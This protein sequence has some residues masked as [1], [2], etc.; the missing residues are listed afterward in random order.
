MSGAF[1]IFIFMIFS[2]S[3]YSQ[4]L[5][6]ISIGEAI[7]VPLTSSQV[8]LENSK[9]IKASAQGPNLK[10]RGIG[11]GTSQL[12][13]GLQ[14]YQFE[15]YKPET[16]KLYDKLT[17][18]QNQIVG[19]QFELKNPWI[20]IQ[21]KIH[22]WS[23]WQKISEKYIQGADLKINAQVNE[24]TKKEA[25][26]FLQKSFAK[27]RLPSQ[28]LPIGETD[29]IRLGQKNLISRYAQ[30]LNPYGFQ[31]IFDE[32]SVEVAP[33]V[34]VEITVAEVKRDFGRKIG[35]QWPESY[36]A[37][38]IQPLVFSA[39]GKLT[40]NA[41]EKN[42]VAKVL[43]NPN[44][45]CRSNKEAEFM[46]GGE[47]PIKIMNR[48]VHD[49]VWKKYGVLL[50]IKPQADLSGRISLSINTEIS[51]IDKANSI[52]DMPAMFTNSVSSHFDLV[53]SKTIMLSGLIKSDSQ[54]N[55]Q[56]L[57][58][59]TQI[60]ILGVLFSSQDFRE[61][62]SELVIFVTPTIIKDEVTQYGDKL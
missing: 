46:A 8:W 61:N 49:V 12:Q 37:Q 3:S 36:Q 40:V 29:E 17:H 6:T 47:I 52:D 53:Q 41:L 57:P 15:V 30:L 26:H 4:S 56:G 35:I 51:S 44:L 48:N 1:L 5:R 9:V 32:T 45:I 58:W 54:Q 23:D 14:T 25:F 2:I 39:N 18:L 59:L 7:L 38:L 11:I 27:H 20:I 21:G 50:K 10:I 43:A 24:M 22:R 33:V 16:L 13:I 42:G 34:K 60:P 19:I 28:V 31:I 55:N 62:R